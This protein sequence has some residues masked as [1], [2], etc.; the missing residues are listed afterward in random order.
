MP[1]KN[2]EE[3]RKHTLEFLKKHHDDKIAREIAISLMQEYNDIIRE[4]GV[5]YE[6]R[7]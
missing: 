7:N 2:A 3:F 5:D 1:N 4:C 6:A